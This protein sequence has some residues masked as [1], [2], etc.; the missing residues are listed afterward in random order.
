MLSKVNNV[1]KSINST[2]FVQGNINYNLESSN[3]DF[4]N[5]VNTGDSYLHNVS[6]NL[7]YQMTVGTTNMETMLNNYSVL[8]AKLASV[9]YG[10]SDGL[11]QGL[12]GSPSGTIKSDSVKS[13]E[14]LA[15]NNIKLFDEK[16]N[17]GKVGKISIND[18]KG[19]MTSKKKAL[20]DEINDSKKLD[21][22][23]DELINCSDISGKGWKAFK[24]ILNNYK[25]CNKVRAK[26]AQTL[27]T[28]YEESEKLI[29]DYISPDEDID[30][31]KIPEY[32]EKIKQLE[33]EIEDCNERITRLEKQNAALAQTEPSPIY[34]EGEI[35]G[36]D[37]DNYYSAQAVIKS[38]NALIAD[39]KE[40]L[41]NATDAK[42]EATEYL[43]K[44]K[45]LADIMSQA[46]KIINAAITSIEAMY[47]DEVYK[48]KTPRLSAIRGEEYVKDTKTTSKKSNIGPMNNAALE[49]YVN[50]YGLGR[51]VSMP[52]V[53]GNGEKVR[54]SVTL[55]G[56]DDEIGVGVND[57]KNLKAGTVFKNYNADVVMNCALNGGPIIIDG[58]V[59]QNPQNGYLGETN[60]YNGLEV[61]CQKQDGTLVSIPFPSGNSKKFINQ[62]KQ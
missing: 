21:S 33:Q 12:F 7:L 48:V 38:N 23:L 6:S 58:E 52:F 22:S 24:D 42:K 20:E 28:A 49:N 54:I 11:E 50:K 2:S 13:F 26:A 17:V 45:G 32:E 39:A 60:K 43:E 47:A 25:S 46:N 19:V 62:L 18:L 44:L 27:Q 35:V 40:L 37:Y 55:F 29:F 61:L 51:T 30:D 8:D 14:E 41:K 10:L 5:S 34:E 16:I 57:G 56:P 31:S 9:A 36:Y 4:F 15:N 3:A 59:L 53:N 1:V